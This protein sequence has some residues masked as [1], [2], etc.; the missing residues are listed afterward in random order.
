MRGKDVQTDVSRGAAPRCL[1]SLGLALALLLGWSHPTSGSWSQAAQAASTGHV[2]AWGYNG[3]GDVGDGTIAS[4]GCYCQSLPEDISAVAGSPLAAVAMSAV[5]V[6]TSQSSLAVGGNGHVYAWG[7]NRYGQLGDG[8]TNGRPGCVCESTPEDISTVGGSPLVGVAISAV[9]GTDLGGQALGSNG[10]VYTWGFNRLGALG[11][12]T[13]LTSGC[14]CQPMPEDISTISGSPLVGVTITAIAGNDQGLALGSNGHVYAW[15]FNREGELGDGT[16]ATTGCDCKP[17]PE[18]ISMVSGSPLAGVT[19]TSI[20]AGAAGS[21]A[22]GSNGHIYAWG[23]NYYGELGDGAIARS[24]CDCR[25]MPEDISNIGGSPLHGVTVTA[26]AAAGLSSFAVGSNG[27]VYAWGI[28]NLGQLGDGTTTT[29]GCLCK[30]TPEDI[31]TV[32]GSALQGA[33]IT[34]ISDG[35]V[36]NLALGSNGHVYAWGMNNN[37]AMGDGTGTSQSLP[38]DISI[39]TGSPLV[40]VDVTAIAG[41]VDHSLAIGIPS[42]PPST[43]GASVAF[44]GSIIAA[45]S[46]PALVNGWVMLQSTGKLVGA[47]TYAEHG[48]AQTVQLFSPVSQAVVV[49]NAPAQADIYGQTRLNGMS[50][51]YKLEITATGSNAYTFSLLLSNGYSTGT[52]VLHN[53]TVAIS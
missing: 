30:P 21:L 27:H 1:L 43:P 46:D 19:V 14:Y 9:S 5:A 2:F 4:G 49:S 39:I 38:E 47:V 6:G 23:D 33:F 34:A 25:P 3:T 31:S 16:I 8:T 10:H 32:G 50:V 11:N 13:T 29:T 35:A 37:D 48:P 44:R 52:Q 20:V 17:L 26:I 22:L 41:G 42:T 40:G 28:N 7:Q 12:G 24:G 18:D 15:G 36:Y 45:D 53:A 51:T